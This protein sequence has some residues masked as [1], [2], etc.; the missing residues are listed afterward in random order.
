MTLLTG[1]KHPFEDNEH[2]I[3]SEVE[4]MEYNL[5]EIQKTTSINGTIHKVK[6]INSNSFQIGDTRDFT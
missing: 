3:I 1:V 5:K 6:V 4:G 2:V